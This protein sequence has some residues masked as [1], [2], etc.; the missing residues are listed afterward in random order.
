LFTPEKAIAVNIFRSP[1]DQK[2]TL[3]KIT[4][5]L[6]SQLQNFTL[7]STSSIAL[8]GQSVER[9]HYS[10]TTGNFETI[11]VE[12]AFTKKNSK[13]FRIDFYGMEDKE[14]DLVLSTFKLI[15]TNSYAPNGMS[16]YQNKRFG[17]SIYVP[18]N[19]S[20]IKGPDET[21]TFAD[22]FLY[23]RVEKDP[24]TGVLSISVPDDAYVMQ[25]DYEL[26]KYMA[27]SLVAW[28][29]EYAR[30]NIEILETGATTTAS[31]IE[32]KYFTGEYDGFGTN[33]ETVR[34]GIKQLF[35]RKNNII[36][37]VTFIDDKNDFLRDE[38]TMYEITK[39]FDIK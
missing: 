27:E 24:F 16:L 10:H 23:E 38:K 7:I 12:S 32:V 14:I 29:K 3:D 26:D 30:Q 31:N 11:D 13:V 6:H 39:S 15:E 4:E 8:G 36:R 25:N 9:I 37:F 20:Y 1:N 35:L 34:L 2:M 21:L 5:V 19:W 33:K 18:G 17:T 22:T 28:K